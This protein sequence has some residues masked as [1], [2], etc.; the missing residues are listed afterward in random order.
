MYRS[1]INSLWPTDIICPHRFGST[2]AQVM[3]CC[4]MA[5]TLTYHCEVF[6]SYG[7]HL[8]AVSQ[9]MLEMPVP[10]MSLKMSAS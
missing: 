10:D 9:E 1:H 5:P 7:I 6:Y 8:R 4:L 3:A 2:L